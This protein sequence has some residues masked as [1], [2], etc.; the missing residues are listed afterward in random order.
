MMKSRMYAILAGVSMLAI[1]LAPFVSAGASQSPMHRVVVFG[2]T[3]SISASLPAGSVLETYPTYLVADL[4]QSEITHL[5]ANGIEVE[6]QD[7]MGQI[8][9]LRYTFDPLN[10]EP[11]I[12]NG[13]RS[14]DASQYY[15]VQAKTPW[16]LE[17][18]DQIEF[19]GAKTY[20]YLPNNAFVVKADATVIGKIRD[21]SFV[22]WIGAYHPAYRISTDL[23]GA[24]GIGLI[25]VLT[26][27]RADV[28]RV[29]TFIA[30][31]GGEIVGFS[32]TSIK[33]LLGRVQAVVGASMIPA[34]A[35]I[36]G[37]S[38]VAQYQ[39][40][41]VV[42]DMARKVTQNYVAYSET[43]GAK[44][45][46][47]EGV[48]LGHTDTGVLK[49]HEA[50]Q[51]SGK[52]LSHICPVGCNDKDEMGHGTH[53]GG[54]VAGDG[55]QYKGMS[56]K[57]VLSTVDISNDA[58]ALVGANDYPVLYAF[59]YNDGARTSS[60]S[61]GA[62]SM[63][64]Y[65]GSSA[66]ADMYMWSH[67][68]FLLFYANGNN[69]SKGAGSVGSPA[70]AKDVISIGASGNGKP[71]ADSLMG[72]SSQGP[73]KDGRIKPSVTA[74]GDLMS[75]TNT[76]GYGSM[77]GTSMACPSASGTSGLIIQYF[78]DGWYPL[79]KAVSA[80]AYTP[81]GSLVKAMAMNSATAMTSAGTIPNGQQGWG[82]LD[83]DNVLYFD[84]ETNALRIVDMTTGLATGDE[85]VYNFTFGAG[86]PL[87]LTL[88]WT[89][90]P[91][92]TIATKQIVNDLDLVVTAPGGTTYYGNNFASGQ[93]QAGGSPDN[94]N[95]E[96]FVLLK[97][98]TA[99]E[100]SVKVRSL[101]APRGPQ[102][103][104]LVASG[105]IV[106]D[107]A[108]L[109]LD[110]A[111]YGDID[112]VKIKLTDGSK[113]S[114]SEQADVT[115]VSGTEVVAEK[116]TLNGKFGLL[117]GPIATSFLPPAPGDSKISVSNGD[118]ITVT[119]VDQNPASIRIAKARV[120]A[121]APAIL[122]V[123][124][125]AISDSAATITW[126]T[127]KSS[128]SKVYYGTSPSLGKTVIDNNMTVNHAVS[129]S[130]LTSTTL[131]FFDVE[132]TD[133]QTHTVKADNGGNHYT[134]TTQGIND[135][136]VVDGSDNTVTFVEFYWEA[137][138]DHGW[139]YTT[140]YKWR[141]GS[142]P[143]AYL[144]KFKVVFWDVV[145]K[146]PPLDDADLDTLK[147][148]NDA[149]G[150]LFFTSQDTAWAFGDSTSG[151]GSAKAS[152]F[153]KFQLKSS[154]KTDPAT[155]SQMK[156]VAGDPVSGAFSGGV[157]YKELRSGGAGDEITSN[158]A[159]GTT[160][161]IWKENTGLNTGVRW[162]ASAANGTTGQGIWGGTPSKVVFESQEL[163]RVDPD[164]HHGTNRGNVMNAT[165]SWLVGGYHPKVKINVP[166]AGQTYSGTVNVAWSAIAFG[167]K[168]IAKQSLY[169]SEDNGQ[170]IN[171]LTTVTPGTFTYA[172][173]TTKSNNSNKYCFKM[174]VEDSGTPPMTG[175]DL[176]CP[177]TVNNAG[178]DKIGPIV[179]PGSIL[180]SPNPA[181]T[182]SP[183]VVDAIIDDTYRG[184]SNIA[185][186]ELHIDDPSPTPGVN[187]T[188]MS[189]KDGSFNTPTETVT[190]SGPHNTTTGTHK[191]TLFGKDS[192]GN[193]G[194]KLDFS[195]NTNPKGVGLGSISGKVK[196]KATGTGIPNAVVVAND[197]GTGNQKGSA[198]AD[199]NGQYTIPIPAGTYDAGASA[200]GYQPNQ[201]NGIVVTAGNSTPG[202]DIELTSIPGQEPGSISGNVKG[203]GTNLQGATVIAYEHGTSNNKGQATT[204]ASG[205]Y[206]IQSLLP[207]IKYDVNASANLYNPAQQDNIVV[208]P[209]TDT[210]N[211]NF[212]LTKKV[213]I[214]GSIAG[215]ITSAGSPL[216]GAT[217]VA[218]TGGT[219]K[220]TATSA[221][222]GTYKIS[223]LD[224]AV[225]KVNASATGC[226]SNEQG[227]VNVDPGQDRTG[228][229]IAL[230]CQ[231][232]VDT[233]TVAGTVTDKDTSNALAGVKVD[234]KQGGTTKATKNTDAAGK[235]TFS[236][237]LV[238]TYDLLFNKT[239][240]NDL[241]ISSFSVTKGQTA[242]KD[243]QMVQKSVAGKATITGTVTD[244][245][246][247]TPLVGVTVTLLQSGT[248]KGTKTTDSNGV[249]TFSNVDPGTYDLK[250]AKSG[251][252]EATKTGVSAV[253]DQTTTVDMQMESKSTPPPPPTDNTMIIVG[254]V[255]AIVIV[256]VIL[257]AILMMRKKKAAPQYPPGY[258]PQPGY[259]PG[260][261][262][263]QA[264][265]YPPGY[266]QQQG[267]EYPPQG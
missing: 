264:G 69:G 44:G 189:A 81:S 41:T 172:W 19:V 237:V 12:P 256:A 61:W 23:D 114:N 52:L 51:G 207:T 235:Y 84:T 116:V 170:T 198:I 173:D 17:W 157:P 159:G 196:D 239:G 220:G 201:K 200:T 210:P 26:F 130:K 102:P 120:D 100:Y 123:K 103:F 240:Y 216:A 233:G 252:N 195:F 155:M 90:Y 214:P 77:Q 215:K 2:E 131:H 111:V 205:N 3:A 238:G 109:S 11:Q 244:K 165:I 79:G 175:S 242:T 142:P 82:R 7:D 161:Y 259:P 143:L 18:R 39:M 176:V 167:G 182:G 105:A 133:M 67:K 46:H 228:I 144:Q 104:S 48:V 63:G 60:N 177:F 80:D 78:K 106:Q 76:G 42:N 110:K 93:S 64:V 119:Y 121:S 203:A 241:T 31:S 107:S 86:A 261:G 230:T 108:L 229:D 118:T 212:D 14:S 227:N 72:F 6:V 190:F 38:Y 147:S 234:L 245:D 145:E 186:A 73:T 112:T 75:T 37:V 1:A 43:V 208:Q 192:S 224:P 71:G 136:L 174:A 197:T 59:N 204:D 206:K 219:D 8:Q 250:F 160:T 194:P 89:D 168:T 97:T 56:Y 21:L 85:V 138:S 199:S 65:T 34:L 98:P 148:Y 66:D 254:A 188:A 83:I 185:A 249:Y 223:N 218:R 232:G 5:T 128:T 74:P 171:F 183:I 181:V 149:G 91:G 150:R 231:G 117:E 36:E 49:T 152:S 54:T 96:E 222:D 58:Q 266:Q 141:D 140:Y 99:G 158:P 154:W 151:Y 129:L 30:K 32:D 163:F 164:T 156:G 248:N 10:G 95:V 226:T 113:A 27:D 55:S 16:K 162:E 169:Y 29:A 126:N 166:A 134:F 146:Y 251:Y 50:F 191:L 213:V 24:T 139:S 243:A 70:T 101:N 25:E 4:Y 209:K 184:S 20:D 88:V 246:K 57:A 15:I 87:K 53:T 122:D 267:G 263:Q 211:I 137:L 187:G 127:T 9:M 236:S 68:D 221:V 125:T 193:W 217:V 262:P 62:D 258:G 92:S 255:L 202:Q 179:V 153:L 35:R 247:S 33:G 22:R 257:V 47:G 265:E 132:S 40:P 28:G 135:I 260:Y 124:V 253:A 225:Y 115:V 45:L 94:T 13:L 180:M 178:S